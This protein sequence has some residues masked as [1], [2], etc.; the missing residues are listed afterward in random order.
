[1]KKDDAM[2]QVDDRYHDLLGRYFNS[3]PH[4]L[5]YDIQQRPN[6]RK[7]VE[8]PWQLLQSKQWEL[9]YQV[10]KNLAFLE[11]YWIF[12]KSEFKSYWNILESFSMFRKNDAYI[13]TIQSP[14]S[15]DNEGTA[16]YIA[17]L[18]MDTGYPNE[19]KHILKVLLDNPINIFEKGYRVDL[20]N[21]YANSLIYTGDVLNAQR[22]FEKAEEVLLELNQK[23]RIIPILLNQSK[24]LRDRGL[25]KKAWNKLQQVENTISEIRNSDYQ[26]DVQIL[27]ASLYCEN[28]NTHKAEELSLDI[29]KKYLLTPEQELAINFLLCKI[30]NSRSSYNRALEFLDQ[31]IKISRTLGEKRS[32]G[33]LLLVKSEIENKVHGTKK[34]MVCIEE[35]EGLFRKI[36]DKN[37]IENCE[38]LRITIAEDEYSVEER[39]KKYE[40]AIN[41]F[42]HSNLNLDL[43]NLQNTMAL[44]LLK[45]EMY[46]EAYSVAIECEALCRTIDNKLGLQAVL[47]TLATLYKLSR[48]FE[49]SISCLDEKI[50]I[51]KSLGKDDSLLISYGNK[52]NIHFA[53]GE[54]DQAIST[55]KNK[56]DM[57]IKNGYTKSLCHSYGNLGAYYIKL[58]QIEKAN[59]YLQ[60]QE[61]LSRE[62]GYVEQLFLSLFNQVIL[63]SESTHI[64]SLKAKIDEALNISNNTNIYP[65][66]RKR[67]FEFKRSI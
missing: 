33:L 53:L 31:A 5:G 50:Q 15:E 51:C 38:I 7:L 26:K 8:L 19:A 63:L 62:F 35:A 43:T 47:S 32:L 3:K 49:K 16:H 23:H 25:L 1:M 18:L 27:K 54:F 2:T 22:Q 48:Q 30:Q 39:I 24:L 17:Q 13:S 59:S 14:Y 9:C 29:C 37:S 28:G 67:L 4:Y 44:D 12:N 57:C 65:N 46:E 52:A 58:D 41:T 45:H 10:F 42:K 36:N 64:E 21:D 66:L 56:I 55:Q 20:L 40:Q 11:Q 60:K 34:A 6:I 61:K